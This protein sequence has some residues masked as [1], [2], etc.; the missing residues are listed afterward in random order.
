[1]LKLDSFYNKMVLFMLKICQ[2]KNINNIKHYYKRL[3]E[4]NWKLNNDLL[5]LYYILLFYK[6]NLSVDQVN[7]IL[8][9]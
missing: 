2:K 1:M 3:E 5:F 8:Q 9:I 4:I 6:I 7:F